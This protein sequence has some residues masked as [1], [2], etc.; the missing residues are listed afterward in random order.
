MT[1]IV[2]VGGSK[3]G[4]A[5][6]TTA[7]LAA[8]GAI[9]RN[10]PAIY[11]VTDPTRKVRGEGRP[12]GVLDGRTP[13]NL[14][15]ILSASRTAT[16]GWLFLDGGGNRQELDIELAKEAD[17]CILPFRA[18][19]E[20]L[21]TVADDM[22]RIPDAL[23]WPAAWTVNA[24]AQKAAE[25]YI[26]ALSKAFPLR[27]I[28]PPIPFVNSVSELLADAL[29]SP[30]TPVRS[31]ARKVFD[32]IDE[33]YDEQRRAASHTTRAEVPGLSRDLGQPT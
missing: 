12:Y 2:Y 7:H 18:S 4:S 26:D 6:T 19:E 28:S 9:L 3:G 32:K 31:L 24:F 25:F 14:A 10:Q 8:L 30:A 17:M 29:G 22:R 20:D 16:T 1:H 15:N 5:K 33:R 23:A 21:D 27:V 13:A 11:V